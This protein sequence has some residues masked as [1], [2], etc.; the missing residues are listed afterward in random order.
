MANLDQELNRSVAVARLRA[1]MASGPKVAVTANDS[2]GAGFR[3]LM[4]AVAISLASAA[5]VAAPMPQAD[6]N[7]IEAQAAAAL[8][9]VKVVIAGKEAFAP[10]PMQRVRWC[11]EVAAAHRLAAH[12]YDWRDV[13]AMV[14][15][16]SSWVARDG[17]GLNK[18]PS[19]GL[20]QMEA[21]TAKSLGIDPHN[22]RQALD[23]VAMLLKESDAWARAKGIQDRKL[24]ASVYYNLSTKA[25][26]AWDG[27]SIDGLPVPTKNHIQNRKAGYNNATVLS[28]KYEKFVKTQLVA[29]EHARQVQSVLNLQREHLKSTPAVL[30]GVQL[31]EDKLAELGARLAAA[32]NTS[33]SPIG[34]PRT[35]AELSGMSVNLRMKGFP[36]NSLRPSEDLARRSANQQRVQL[37]QQGLESLADAWRFAAASAADV[38]S[39]AK[40]VLASASKPRPGEG[41]AESYPVLVHTVAQGGTGLVAA[42]SLSAKALEESEDDAGNRGR[43]ASLSVRLSARGIDQLVRDAEAIAAAPGVVRSQQTELAQALQRLAARCQS[44]SVAFALNEQGRM[45]AFATPGGESTRAVA[46]G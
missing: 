14:E 39:R 13:Y 16:E 9:P 6:K 2:S 44:K 19:F 37:R 27:R 40:N 26:N 5:S 21:A 24:A 29:A 36:G 46:R 7:F 42:T 4:G 38:V 12:G 33:D 45:V 35:L 23:G 22:P 10:H 30:A 18:R 41:I 25:R 1:V 20:A 11:K 32:S 34:G 28:F 8:Q 17:M 15:A 31:S 43:N 3:S